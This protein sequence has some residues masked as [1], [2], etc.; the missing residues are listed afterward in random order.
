M[1]ITTIPSAAEERIVKTKSDFRT[2]R[3]S[4]HVIIK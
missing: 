2:L 3:V 4:A 1:N